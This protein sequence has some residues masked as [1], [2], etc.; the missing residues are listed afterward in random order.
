MIAFQA[1]GAVNSGASYERNTS[2]ADIWSVVFVIEA[3]DK[4][5]KRQR[6]SMFRLVCIFRE[7]TSKRLL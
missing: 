1:P 5:E 6:T 4:N 3:A 2:L 7:R